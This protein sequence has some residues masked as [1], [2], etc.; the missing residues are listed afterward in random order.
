MSHCPV[1]EIEGLVQ[2]LRD[3]ERPEE[4]VVRVEPRLTIMPGDFVALLGPSG[5]GKTTLL[6]VLGLLRA[7]TDPR[8]LTRFSLW[9]EH[10]A[11]IQEM[12]LKDAW[13]HRRQGKIETVRRR[14]IGFALQ[15]GELL[16]ALTVRENIECP[17]HLNGWKAGDRRDRANHLIDRF[18]L[19]RSTAPR[20]VSARCSAAADVY[21][22]ANARV[23][24]LSGGEYQR[25]SLARAIAHKPQLVFVDEPTAA[26]NRELARG[27]LEQLRLM[28]QHERRHAATVMITHDEE[29]ASDFANVV[30][31]MEPARDEAGGRVVAVERKATIEK[32]NSPV[33]L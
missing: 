7:P 25:V 2:R 13:Q 21:D 18:S 8:S 27:A 24:K 33:G 17:L 11:K 31:R 16:P 19:R 29:L 3:D 5:C 28:L 6:T 10:E 22:L 15:S 20:T 12:N 14:H 4:F 26:L 32:N 9:V 30:I 23:N 1:L